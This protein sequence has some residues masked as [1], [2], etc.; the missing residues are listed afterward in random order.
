MDSTF[1]LLPL[2]QVISEIS[3]SISYLLFHTFLR[4]PVC[5]PTAPRF[6]K[7]WEPRA[8][9]RPWTAHV[10][11]GSCCVSCSRWPGDCLKPQ[12]QRLRR[13][14]HAEGSVAPPR[15]WMRQ[16][17]QREV[18]LHLEQDEAAWGRRGCSLPAQP[19]AALEL[20]GNTH[21]RNREQLCAG[22]GR[23]MGRNGFLCRESCTC[24]PMCIDVYVH[25]C[26]CVSVY[27]CMCVLCAGMCLCMC[28]CMGEKDEM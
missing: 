6:L 3:S 8:S 22:E 13:C 4:E 12:A 11:L 24:A 16:P 21:V 15:A 17:A 23:F 20:H 25:G 28:L 27:M 7:S 5:T 19:P 14:L 26:T 10:S 18:W 2:Q 9:G 1:K